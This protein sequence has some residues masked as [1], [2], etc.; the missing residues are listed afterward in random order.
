[1][2]QAGEKDAGMKTVQQKITLNN[3]QKSCRNR[4]L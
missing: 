2:C 1:M 4:L 3:R